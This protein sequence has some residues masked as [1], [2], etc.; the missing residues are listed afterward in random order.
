MASSTALCI[1]AGALILARDIVTDQWETPKALGTAVGVVAASYVSAGL[2]G[3][4]PGF[5]TSLAVVLV[6]GVVYTTIGPLS[7]KLFAGG[8]K[9][10][11]NP[12]TLI[13]VPAGGY[14]SQ[15]K[16]KRGA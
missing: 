9:I 1:T 16:N 4:A 7:E 14:G 13:K 10:S 11:T 15:V 12:K 8:F 2:N 3:V 6:V 5:G